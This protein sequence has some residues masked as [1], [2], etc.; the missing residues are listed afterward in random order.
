MQQPTRRSVVAAIA[1]LPLVAACSSGTS[2]APSTPRTPTGRTSTQRPGTV[3]VLGSVP[4]SQLAA[5]RAHVST[6]MRLVS[7]V[8]R[9][10][11]STIAVR[12]VIAATGEE[13]ARLTGRP[14]DGTVPAV[15][16]AAG[17]VAIHPTLWTST[18]APGR[19]VVITHEL[20]HVALGQGGL[21]GVP[22]WVVEGSAELTAYRATGLP[23]ATV[24]PSLA[25]EVAAGRVPGGPPTDD[26]LRLRSRTVLPLGYQQAWAWCTFLVDRT[27]LEAFTRFV[28]AADAGDSGAFRRTYG[29]TPSS[30][31][32][33][34]GA[35][36]RRQL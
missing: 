6:G 2:A 25:R 27:G 13:F 30:L 31:G 35:W 19:Q 26:V 34:Y 8:W 22:L 24:A 3:Q 11:W 36:L 29:T 10:R 18:S 23:A 1:S 16:T 5:Y 17:L 32:P 9:P 15:T 12:V 4:A 7:E 33:T 20:T 28:R 14:A 21:T